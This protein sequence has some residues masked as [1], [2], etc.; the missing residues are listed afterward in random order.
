MGLVNEVVELD[1]L[2]DAAVD[3]WCEEMLSLSPGCLGDPEGQSFD[4]EMDGYSE[5]GVISH[6]MYP[7]W[8]DSAECAE[9]PASFTERRKPE[10]WKIRR[11]SS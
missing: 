8:F 5:M 1:E 11:G 4:Q 2:E 6:S 7:D 3:R 9:G 10:F